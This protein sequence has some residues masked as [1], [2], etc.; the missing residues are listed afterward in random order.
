MAHAD[1]AERPQR[2]TGLGITDTVYTGYSALESNTSYL[3]TVTARL[4]TGDSIRVQSFSTFVIL[5][6]HSPIA[7]VL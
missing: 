7:T 2:P 4:S 5:S 3:W 1:L 6:A